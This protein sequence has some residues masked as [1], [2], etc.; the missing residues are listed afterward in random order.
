MCFHVS[1]IIINKC[2]HFISNKYSFLDDE[3]RVALNIINGDP[4]SDYINASY[5]EVMFE[6]FHCVVNF[7]LNLSTDLRDVKVKKII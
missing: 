2:I 3:N 5:I 1:D 7:P 4:Y 6:T